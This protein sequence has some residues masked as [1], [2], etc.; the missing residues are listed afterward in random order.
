MGLKSFQLK[1][2]SV[3]SHGSYEGYEGHEE[4]LREA[5][6]APRLCREEW[7][8]GVRLVQGRPGEEQA[9]QDCEQEERSEG[10]EEPMDRSR[11]GGQEGPRHQGL[12]RHQEGFAPLQE[13]QGAPQEVRTVRRAVWRCHL[14]RLRTFSGCV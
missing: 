12:L 9:R 1:R 13:G 10:Q 6:E 5:C 11:G 14:K 7:E 4:D 2:S 8:D 3:V